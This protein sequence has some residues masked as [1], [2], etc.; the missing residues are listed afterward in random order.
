[1]KGQTG[2]VNLESVSEY[3][4]LLLEEIDDTIRHLQYDIKHNPFQAYGI[5]ISFNFLKSLG[6]AIFTILGYVIQ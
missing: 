5:T 6:V 3:I 1:M 2:K 4:E